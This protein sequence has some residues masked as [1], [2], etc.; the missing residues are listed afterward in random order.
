MTSTL[1]LS[2]LGWPQAAWLNQTSAT[3]IEGFVSDKALALLIYLACTAETQS[4]TKMTGLLWGDFP[5]DKARTSLRTALHNLNQ[6][7]EPHV[8]AQRKTLA[9]DH[10]HPHW[11]DTAEFRTLLRRH[12]PPTPTTPLTAE[13]AQGL[14]AAVALYQGDFLE[15]FYIDDAPEFEEWMLIERERLRQ[16][17]LDALAALIHHDLTAAQ[18]E[19]AISHTRRLLAMEPWREEAHRQLMLLLARQGDF[20]AALRQYDKCATLL[21]EELGVEPMPETAALRQRILQL[22]AQPPTSNL[23][24]AENRFF[25]REAEAAELAQHL[26]QP[27]TRLITLIGPGGVGKTRLALETAARYDHLFLDRACYVPLTAATSGEVLHTTL[28]RALGLTFRPPQRPLDQITEA[29][30]PRE[31]LLVLDNAEHLVDEVAELVRHLLANAPQ[32]TLLVTS[33]ERLNLRQEW[34][35]AV[36]GLPAETAARLFTHHAQRVGWGGGDGDENEQAI[37]RM[38]QLLGGLPLGLELAAAQLAHTTCGELAERLAQTLD[39]VASQWRDIPARHR[40]LRAIFEQSWQSLT[41]PEQQL[42]VQLSMFRG[43]FTGQAAVAVAGATPP[44]LAHLLA[45]SLLQRGSDGRYR[46]HE[47]LRQY[48][49]ERLAEG[50]EETAVATAHATYYLHQLQ[51]QEGDDGQASLA[52]IRTET[53]NVRW[54]WRTAARH[55]LAALLRVAITRLHQFYE[56][57]GWFAEAQAQMQEAAEALQPIAEQVQ[58]TAEE[59]LAY[60]LARSHQAAFLMRLGQIGPAYTAAEQA[61]HWLASLPE[62]LAAEHLI[63]NLNLQGILHMAKGEFEQAIATLEACAEA[64]RQQNTV[65]LVK[66]LSNLGSLYMRQGRY[67]E[68]KAV[69]QEGIPLCRATNNVLGL[70]HFLSNLGGIHILLEEFA[71]AVG[72]LTEGLAIAQQ[73][74][75]PHVAVVAHLNLAEAHLKLRQL[76]EAMAGAQAGL[77][78]AEKLGEQRM[79]A[80]MGKLLAVAQHGAGE[81]RAAWATLS[82]ALTAAEQTGSPPVLL[83]VLDGVG[84]LWVAEGAMGRARPLLAFIAQH[85][86][87]ES[88]HKENAERLLGAERPPVPAEQTLADVVQHIKGKLKYEV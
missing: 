49:A 38:V 32:L 16:G 86:A 70:S 64:C 21:D 75:N 25:G 58:A 78:L 50:G 8:D 63:F 44:L 4:R 52:L 62:S 83:D 43:G 53:D 71:E 40:S 55:G 13:Q 84:Q 22:R 29:L 56:M 11:L 9:F 69:L 65:Q 66:P 51:G 3:P 17:M 33:R 87:V 34:V 85:P 48:A 6:L 30:A 79:V 72:V 7:I 54:A 36:E 46:C 10:S 57:Q 39:V 15:G 35:F 77:A 37:G 28:G 19:T 68:G 67:A 73:M 24:P 45:K 2:L 41:P 61:A 74:N 23:P 47:V 88:Q 27:E 14:M 12:L 80:R 1:K 82:A 5:E 26:L 60:A 20:N 31:L 18:Y 42:F 76:P 81:A 59:R